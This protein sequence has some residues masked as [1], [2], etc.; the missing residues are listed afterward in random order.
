L[1]PVREW[2]TWLW[3]E[4]EPIEVVDDN[5]HQR[6][7]CF[8]EITGRYWE[9]GTRDGPQGSGLTAIYLDKMTPYGGAEIPCDVRIKELTGPQEHRSLEH[10]ENHWYIRPN[11]PENKGNPAYNAYGYRQA[12]YLDSYGYIDGIQTEKAR[13]KEVP[14]NGDLCYDRKLDCRRLI[15][16][17]YTSTSEF[18]VAKADCYINVK[19]MAGIRSERTM[20]EWTW[21]AEVEN[22]FLW[23]TRGY[24]PLL[25]RA[26]NVLCTGNTTPW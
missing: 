3:P 25:N 13:T 9:F 21:Q 14:D 5:G 23:V 12:F 7:L 11:K 17:F 26:T 18:K 6:F 24:Q 10:V 2:G 16:G 20:K 19:D 8:D 15:M 22:M 1:E 4:T